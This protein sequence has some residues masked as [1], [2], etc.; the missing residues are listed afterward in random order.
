[1]VRYA[2]FSWISA[3]QATCRRSAAGDGK[4][5]KLLVRYFYLGLGCSEDKAVKKEKMGAGV[6]GG[7]AS[8]ANSAHL[9]PLSFFVPIFVGASIRCFSFTFCDEEPGRYVGKS[10][11]FLAIRRLYRFG[12]SCGI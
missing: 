3:F 8:S 10:F 9:P 12:G 6:A 1:M 2:P 5:K 11:A 4:E 7:Q